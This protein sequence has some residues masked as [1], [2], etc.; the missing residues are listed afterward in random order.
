MARRH[1]A[2][3]AAVRSV[4]RS[5]EWIESADQSFVSVAATT[6]LIH[7]SNATLGTSTIV[8]TRGLLAIKFAAGNN[9]DGR[10]E[11]A[12]GIAIVSAQAFAVGATAIPA[13]F[14]EAGWD[15]WFFHQFFAISQ[16]AAGTVGN[17]MLGTQQKDVDSKAMR[18]LR[19]NTN[20]AVV[21][22]ENNSGVAIEVGFW[23]RMLLKLT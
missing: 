18:K 13:P 20:V 22:A 11:G 19:D 21:M 23:F 6:S 17:L 15:G 10:V 8:R 16:E 14:T 2:G 12:V 1:F 9:S 7:Q 5:T 3:R 4:K